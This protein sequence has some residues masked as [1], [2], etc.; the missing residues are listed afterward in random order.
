MRKYLITS[1]VAAA[2]AVAS[3][4]F[5]S[6]L[7]VGG[8]KAGASTKDDKPK[9]VNFIGTWHQIDGDPSAVMTA[10]IS[11]GAIQINL[12]TRDSSN[13]YWLGTFDTDMTDVK[14]FTMISNGD[15]DAMANMIFASQDSTKKFT[16][17]D[18]VLSF[19]F[20]ILG[21]TTTVHLTK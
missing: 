19:D 13:V 3:F 20:S 16:Y 15:Q 9:T 10:E 2:L 14:A 8:A 6:P 4:L 18:G 21:T 5:L 17:R 1:L 12:K 11:F 7:G